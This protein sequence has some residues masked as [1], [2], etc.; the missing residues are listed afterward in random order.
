MQFSSVCLITPSPTK[1]NL[2][3]PFYCTSPPSPPPQAQSSGSSVVAVVLRDEHLRHP[4]C[5]VK[6]EKILLL[7]FQEG[8]ISYEDVDNIWA[9]LVGKDEL[10]VKN[11]HRL[12][13]KVACDLHSDQLDEFFEHFQVK[14]G[15]KGRV[16]NVSDTL[17]VM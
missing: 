8:L 11:T 3:L 6:L 15:E 7:C 4:Q 14:R 9:N 12:L 2:L 10:V 5:V 16:E 17:R 1:H 13:A